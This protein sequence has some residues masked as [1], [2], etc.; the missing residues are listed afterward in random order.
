[1]LHRHAMVNQAT[2]KAVLTLDQ[3][4]DIARR[5]DLVVVNGPKFTPYLTAMRTVNPSLK[6]LMYENAAFAQKSEGS[7]YPASWYAQSLAGNWVTSTYFGNYFMDIRNPGW[8]QD[9]VARCRSDL[10]V[11]KYD[12]C[13]FDMLLPAPLLPGYLTALPVD[14][15]TGQVWTNPAFTAAIRDLAATL[16]A[17]LT[18]IPLGGNALTTG[19]RYFATDGTSNAPLLDVLDVGHDEIWLRGGSQSVSKYPTEKEW[20]RSVNMLVEAASRGKQVQAQTKLWTSATAAQAAAWHRYVVASFLLGTDGNSYL[21]FSVSQ[22]LAALTADSP[23]DRVDVGTPLGGFAKVDGVYQRQFTGGVSMVNPTA[24]AVT[25]PL[26]AA[27]RT[28][29]GVTV[30]GSLVLGPNS[31]EVLTSV[32]PAS[33]NVPSISPLAPR[34]PGLVHKW[35]TLNQVPSDTLTSQEVAAV[36]TNFDLAVVKNSQAALVDQLKATNPALTALVYHNGAFAQKNE[37]TRFPASWYAYDTYH[38]KITQTVFGNYLMDVSNAD[39]V[40]HVVTACSVA[41]AQAHADGCYTDMMMTAPLFGDYVTETPINPATGRAWTF[42]GFQSAVERIASRVR[43][44]VPGPSAANGVGRGKRWFINDGGSSKTLTNNTDG[45]HAEIWLRNRDLGPEEFPTVTAWK[46]DVDM[47]VQ[48]EAESRQLMV[49]TKLWARDGVAI[50]SAVVDRWRA[51]ALASFLL[52]TE[53]H[54]WYLF[55]HLQTLRGMTAADPWE[56]VAVG[57]P[58]GAYTEVGGVYTRSFVNGFVAVDPSA[59]DSTV[60]LPPGNWRSLDGQLQS[61]TIAM[62]ARTGMVWTLVP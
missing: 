56:Q 7:K 53:G 55:S 23:Y 40:N 33:S 4:L 6:V 8:A 30:T 21:N 49:E 51:F 61:G 14:P 47:V 50:S 26:T 48:A 28:L 3:A 60:A 58:T 29:D 43:D 5:Y 10:T 59:T 36:A 25:V 16:R 17:A 18:D 12:G 27:Y 45:S 39:W 9:D 2:D 62:A 20:L 37:G 32:A 54:T 1:M 57:A 13:Y 35:V 41:R 15:K 31:G 11:N 24:A 19:G 46:Q 52:A 38:N 44:E 42:P 22:T 34:T